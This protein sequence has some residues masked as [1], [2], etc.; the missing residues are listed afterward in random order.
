MNRSKAFAFFQYMIVN[1]PSLNKL[2]DY[3]L[4]EVKDLNKNYF[5]AFKKA[6]QI[7]KIESQYF[8]REGRQQERL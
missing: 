7:S 6:E 8:I 5:I 2:S 3:L 1:Q 4:F